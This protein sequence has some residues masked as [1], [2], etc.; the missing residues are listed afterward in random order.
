MIERQTGAKIVKLK[1][2]RGGEY[3]SRE[4]LQFLTNE[5]IQTERGP[6]DRPMANSV[7][8]RFNWTLLSRIRSQLVQCGLPLSMWG[9]LAI[10][11]SF[12][13]NCSPSKAIQFQSPLDLF[14]SI[15]PSH[16]HPFKYDRLK[17]FGCLAYALNRN[18]QS[19]VG[20]MANRYISVGIEPNARAWR[21]WDKNSKR[22]LVTRD[23][24]FRETIFPAAD[25]NLTPDISSFEHCN[26]GLQDIL[27]NTP[28]F[29][30]PTPNTSDLNSDTPTRHTTESFDH[31]TDTPHS[32]QLTQLFEDQSSET[33]NVNP[34]T[35]GP[36]SSPD[37]PTISSPTPEPAPTACTPT[38]HHRRTTR[39][40]TQPQRYGFATTVTND[41]DHPTFTQA[42]AS[43]T[44]SV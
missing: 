27:T 13:I 5:G 38:I 19:K 2:D 24:Q 43:P 28:V 12:Q 22:I 7:S 26:S 9:E 30:T 1:T 41:S 36:T 15:T 44:G 18:R 23:A 32:E 6:A 40:A 37:P 8:E 34:S 17:P 21:L 4:F 3:S 39:K 35:A 33:S 11:S 14:N 20:P 25:R 10:Y 42:M 31:D 29:H 16:T